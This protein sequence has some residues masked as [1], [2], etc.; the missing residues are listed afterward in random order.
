MAIEAAGNREANMQAQKRR[1]LRAKTHD[2][3]FAAHALQPPPAV[4]QAPAEQPAKA[5]GEPLES[6]PAKAAVQPVPVEAQAAA[7]S[8]EPVPLEPQ[9]AKAAVE[10]WLRIS[11]NF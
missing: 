1:R 4:E 10:A 2:E 8:V 6:Q 11:R 9:P 7:A 3:A 5:A